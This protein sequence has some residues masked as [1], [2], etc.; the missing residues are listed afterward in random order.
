[1]GNS[2][3][4]VFRHYKMNVPENECWQ[5]TGSVG[6]RSRALRP[7]FMFENRRMLAYRIVYELV[8]GVTL[9]SDQLIKHSCDNGSMPV[10]CGNPRHLS[11]G[12]HIENMDDMKQ[13]QR[14]GLPHSVVK[15]IRTL[16]EGGKPQHEIALLYGISRSLV[17]R[18]VD[19]S[20]YEHVQEHT[21]DDG[22]TV[23]GSE[24]HTGD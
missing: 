16:A 17:S 10:G 15:A 12:T 8:H 13:R 22:D 23:S 3:H 4:D 5:W 2:K 18:I 1:M 20:I 19:R 6:G 21:D 9:T 14:H 24:E 11:V 7:Y